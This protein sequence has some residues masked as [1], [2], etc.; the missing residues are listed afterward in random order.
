MTT[1]RFTFA[2]AGDHLVF[3]CTGSIDW[4]GQAELIEAIRAASESGPRKIVIDYR[5]TVGP[6]D[7]LTKYKSG[8]LAAE[9]LPG[10]RILSLGR[11]E[12]I[13]H[14][15]ENTAVNRGAQVFTT[16]DEAE[17]MRWLMEAAKF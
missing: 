10:R 13:D 3:T 16:D 4:P 6:F 15:A 1:L 5:P 8:V 7:T 11:R 12:L 14:F 9:K 17:G 2:N